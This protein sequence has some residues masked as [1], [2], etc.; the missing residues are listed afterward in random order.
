[1]AEFV[2]KAAIGFKEVHGGQSNPECTHVILTKEEYKELI[3]RI[4]KAERGAE[5][6]RYIAERNVQDEK[7]RARGRIDEVKAIFVQKETELKELLDAERKECELQRGLN[8]NLLRIAR[9]RANADRKLR[10]KKEHSGYV[11]IT[12]M[13]KEHRYK[14]I[15]DGYLKY[16]TL[17]ETVLETPYVVRLEVPEVKSLTQELFQYDE[18]EKWMIS[19][20]G[21]NAKYERGYA[22]MIRNKDWKE[23]AR[24]N[25]MVDR[26][27][28]ANYRTGYWEIIFLHTKPLSS[29]PMDM[30]PRMQ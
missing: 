7:R 1:M 4:S 30:M 8:E 13:E 6:A 21:I 18:N 24:C 25:V 2:R 11:V 12:S 20:I 9:E 22:D 15:D 14:D 19:R 27:L 3:E 28:K 10:P 26:R 29:V 5:E 23:H 17:W 16:V